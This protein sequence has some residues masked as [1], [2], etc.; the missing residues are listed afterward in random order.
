MSET[1]R[2]NE[3]VTAVLAALA[4]T[5]EEDAA[6]WLCRHCEGY[7]RWWGLENSLEEI[8]G[9][10]GAGEEILDPLKEAQAEIHQKQTN[11][12]EIRD[13]LCDDAEGSG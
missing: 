8:R 4:R 11:I 6:H 10:Y 3:M 12:G 2:A 13:R 1:P 5:P 9:R 7:E